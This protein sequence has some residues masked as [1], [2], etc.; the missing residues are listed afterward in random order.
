MTIETEFNIREEVTILELNATGRILAIYS[1]QSGTQ[2]QVRYFYGGKAETVYF[3]P[4]E[5]KRKVNR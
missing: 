4:D 3:F 5:L 2:Y 1:N